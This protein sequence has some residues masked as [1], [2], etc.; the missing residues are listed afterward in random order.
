[1][2]RS[3]PLNGMKSSR[4]VGSWQTLLI[5]IAGKRRRCGGRISGWPRS[6]PRISCVGGQVM[7][8]ALVRIGDYVAD[9]GVR[10]DG[11]YQAARDL[12]LR[13]SPRV[14]DEPL[15]RA[16]ETTVEAAV[17]LCGHLAGGV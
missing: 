13:E 16:G 8:E 14:G 4:P 6:R 11:P 17:R 10:G 15:H 5:G 9:H 1:M 3:I 7:A 2:F 12:L